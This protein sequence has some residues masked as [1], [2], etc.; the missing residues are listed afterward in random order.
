[1]GGT[2]GRHR[3]AGDHVVVAP[4][5]AP[6]QRCT[7]HLSRSYGTSRTIDTMFRRYVRSLARTLHAHDARSRMTFTASPPWAMIPWTRASARKCSRRAL[8][9]LNTATTDSGA[10]I[11]WSGDRDVSRTSVD[12]CLDAPACE[13]T[14]SCHRLRGRMH[15][16]GNI[17]T[18]IG[19]VASQDDLAPH[20]PRP[21]SR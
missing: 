11:P 12:R 13:R 14:A 20:P 6:I 16:C 3:R 8:T 1:M 17:D 18:I 21:V 5:F 19:T 4:G 9:P 15:H 10:L 2:V 7:R